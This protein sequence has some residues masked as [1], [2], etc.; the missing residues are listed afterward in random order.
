MNTCICVNFVK[1][2]LMPFMK[3]KSS[4]W[5]LVG[6][7]FPNR[8][9]GDDFSLW[10]LLFFSKLWRFFVT[11]A[12]FVTVISSCDEI[13]G[14]L[15]KIV[16]NFWKRVAEIQPLFASEKFNMMHYFMFLCPSTRVC[17]NS[18]NNLNQWRYK[19]TTWLLVVVMRV[20]NHYVDAT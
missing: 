2:T 9:S 14:T 18:V 5:T 10:T 15:W 20:S 7:K 4:I 17:V 19:L 1:L 3:S 16:N 12:F 6:W 8:R 11:H 13:D